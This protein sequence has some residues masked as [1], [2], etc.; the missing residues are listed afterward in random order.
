MSERIEFLPLGS[1]VIINGG[2]KKYMIIARGLNVVIN[3]QKK[4]FDYGGCLY[5]EGVMGDQML[6]FQHQ[7]I[8]ETIFTGYADDDNRI[9]VEN[10][11]EA[12]EKSDIQ[13]A[14]VSE[15]KGKEA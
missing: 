9:M 10:I 13:H 7:D 3:G 14:I 5:P 1:I 8:K 4:F 15:L 12:M 6:Y 11:Q 2:V